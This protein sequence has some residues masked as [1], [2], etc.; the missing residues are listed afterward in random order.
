MPNPVGDDEIKYM[1]FSCF[2]QI[3]FASCPSCGFEQ[4]IPSRWQV[5]FTCGKCS[6]KVEIPRTRYYSK[7]TKAVGVTGYGYTWPRM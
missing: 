3:V 4:A 5:A 7:S 2:A 1:C 6:Q